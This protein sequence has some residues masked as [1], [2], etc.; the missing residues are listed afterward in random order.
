MTSD[1]CGFHELGKLLLPE[2]LECKAEW[3][4]EQSNAV[5][6]TSG[7]WFRRSSSKSKACSRN[8]LLF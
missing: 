5:E 3:K 4:N 8:G 2:A 1:E 7:P 6:G